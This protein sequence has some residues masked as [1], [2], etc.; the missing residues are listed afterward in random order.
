M[1]CRLRTVLAG[2]GWPQ[3][4]MYWYGRGGGRKTGVADCVNYGSV[5]MMPVPIINIMRCTPVA[6]VPLHLSAIKT[7]RNETLQHTNQP[8]SILSFPPQ[9]VLRVL[10]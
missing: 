8:I 10:S 4:D 7:C 3:S 1:T 2:F 9:T 5:S 6:P